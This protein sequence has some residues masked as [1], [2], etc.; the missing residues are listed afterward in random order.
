[1]KSPVGKL[2]VNEENGVPRSF[3]WRGG[4]YSIRTVLEAWKDTGR[5]WKD[6]APKFFFR[7]ET[8]GGGLWEI[9]LDTAR[10]EWHLYKVYD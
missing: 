8:T 5:W 10:Y 7:V 1:M 2:K 4:S 6:E 9:Y 3:C